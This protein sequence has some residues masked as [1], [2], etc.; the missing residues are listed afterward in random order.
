MQYSASKELGYLQPVEPEFGSTSLHTSTR[1]HLPENGCHKTDKAFESSKFSC[2]ACVHFAMP[3]EELL[4]LDLFIFGHL[5]HGTSTVGN[6]IMMS[7]ALSGP[8]A[9]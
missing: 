5:L 6:S 3:L 1:L 2:A 9:D 4:S 8:S 7:K